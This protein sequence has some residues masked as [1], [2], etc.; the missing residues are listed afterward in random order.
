MFHINSKNRRMRR[1]S[2]FISFF[3][4]SELGPSNILFAKTNAK[5]KDELRLAT[6]S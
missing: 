4:P 5:T 2:R 6:L 1:L 3:S